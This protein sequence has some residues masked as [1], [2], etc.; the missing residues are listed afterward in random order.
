MP[1]SISILQIQVQFQKCNFKLQISISISFFNFNANLNFQRSPE[2][3]T[4][5]WIWTI[6]P[7]EKSGTPQFQLDKFAEI[8]STW[9]FWWLSSKESGYSYL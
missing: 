7:T 4:K 8:R 2:I 1:T 3:S 5:H 9:N 6:G